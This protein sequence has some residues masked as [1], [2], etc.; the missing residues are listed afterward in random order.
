MNKLLTLLLAM[1]A[2]LAICQR[3][4][5]GQSP[6]SAKPAAEGTSGKTTSS[7]ANVARRK[8]A[9]EVIAA[10]L[11]IS[12]PAEFDQCVDANLAIAEAQVVAE[13][14]AGARDSLKKAKAAADRISTEFSRAA[15]LPAYRRTG[16]PNAGL[17]RRHCHGRP[18]QQRQL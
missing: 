10:A 18:N 17:R 15:C 7:Q 8:A 16:R 14:M 4:I 2:A 9:L 11:K 3:S 6:T 5:S 12:Q 13:E 1:A